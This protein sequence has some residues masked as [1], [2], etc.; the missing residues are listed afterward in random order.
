MFRILA[1]EGAPAKRFRSTGECLRE[2]VEASLFAVLVLAT[3]AS[4]AATIPTGPVV[5]ISRLSGYCAANPTNSTQSGVRIVQQPCSGLLNE[6]WTLQPVTEGY[7]VV[8]RL[9][10]L[11]LDVAYSSTAD[12]AKVQQWACNGTSAQTWM[13][14]PNSSWFQL[15]AR[16]SGKCLNVSSNS[17]NNGAWLNQATCASVDQQRWTISPAPLPST[18]ST[19]ILFSLV[20]VAAANLADGR[21]MAWS[22]Y[23]RFKFGGDRGMTYTTVFDPQTGRSTET[24]VSNTGHDMFCPGTTL[25]A[26]GRLLVSGG[27]SSYKTSIF[28]P[29]TGTWSTSNT[30]NIPRGYEANTL[31]SRREVLTLGGSWNGGSPTGT[32]PHGGIGGKHAEIWADGLGWRRLTGVPVDQFLGTDPG[33]VYR[34]DN[35]MWLIAQSNGWVFHAGPSSQM[36]WINT[37]GTGSVVDAGPRGLDPYS[38][39]GTAVLYDTGRILK[40]GGAAAYDAYASSTDAAHVIDIRGGPS[41]PVSVRK[42]APMQ[43]RRSLHNGVVLPNGQVVIIGGLNIS[44]NFTDNTAVLMPEL[45]DPRTETFARLS[46]MATPRNYHSVALLLLDGRVFAGG[47]GLCGT[48]AYNHPDAEILTPPYLLNA[49]GTL[50][51]RPAIVSAPTSAKLGATIT[52][53]TN[54]SVTS[55]ALVR[56]SAVTHGI[57]NDQRRIPLP[58]DGGT[59]TAGYTLT[60][61][62]DAGVVLPGNYM[63][64]AMSATGRPSYAKVMNI[65]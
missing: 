50:A 43:F 44:K 29:N 17:H 28:N 42:I 27:S 7:R 36:H 46:P 45:W 40:L 41:V 11:C 22:A 4:E 15:V 23:D 33:G 65:R 34:S 49:D 38:I 12:F 21:V 48:C 52:V 31:T 5:L 53:R 6:Q 35:H 18:W 32:T 62:S 30:M 8:S 24:L 16:V 26:D 14:T 20:P 58:I 55:F 2:L 54:P 13:P 39:T 37:T 63:L 60:I 3:P 1:T 59:N 9:N 10:G 47:G 51:P 19:K 64:F 56:M 57:N 61:P 25:L